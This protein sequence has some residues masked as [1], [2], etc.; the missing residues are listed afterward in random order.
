MDI[1]VVYPENH[2]AAIGARKDS[3]PFLDHSEGKG[4]SIDICSYARVNLGYKDLQFSE[5]INMPMPDLMFC[6]NNICTCNLCIY[7][8]HCFPI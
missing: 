4:Y 6:C 8:N 7:Q 5:A 3:M 1:H 2:A